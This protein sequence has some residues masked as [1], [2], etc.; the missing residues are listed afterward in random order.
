MAWRGWICGWVGGWPHREFSNERPQVSARLREG[1]SLYHVDEQRLRDAA[2]TLLITQNL[3][4]V[5]GPSGNE[6]TQVLKALKPAPTILW[7]TPKT[8]HEVLEAYVELGKHTGKQ[9]EAEAWVAASLRGLEEI[10][11]RVRALGKPPTRVAFFEWIDPVYAAGHWVRGWV[12]WAG[13]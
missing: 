9:A 5:C 3:C 4:Q 10:K 6:V 8:F 11:A 1:K 13:G 7:Q 2:P 12:E